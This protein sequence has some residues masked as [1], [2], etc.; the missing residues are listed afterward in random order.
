MIIYDK[1]TFCDSIS[2]SNIQQNISTIR[3]LILAYGCA[4]L[5]TLLD[6]RSAA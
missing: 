5:P 3:T 2:L 1:G 4:G 6:E